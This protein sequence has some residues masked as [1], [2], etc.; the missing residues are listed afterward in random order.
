MNIIG[1][2]GVGPGTRAKTVGARESV[3]RHLKQRHDPITSFLDYAPE[4]GRIPINYFPLRGLGH[5][6]AAAMLVNGKLVAA[7][8]EERLNR[9]KHSISLDGENLLPRKS[10]D[11]CLE[12]AE[13]SWKD[14]DYICHYLDLSDTVMK[15]RLEILG[16]VLPAEVR[17][18]VLRANEVSF[19]TE[20]S[21]ESVFKQLQAL[22]GDA[23]QEHK[24]QCVPHHLSHAAASY[25]SSGFE[26]AGV[27][28]LDGYGEKDSAL[29]SIGN[30][31]RLE[32]IES[33][34]IPHSLGILYMVVTVFLGFKALNDEY[35]VMGLAPYGDPARYRNAFRDLI[36]VDDKGGYLTPLLTQPNLSEHLVGLFGPARKPEDPVSQREM[37]IAASLQERLEEVVL[38][39]LQRL[40]HEYGFDRLCLSGGVALNSVLNGK[41]AR[42]GL[43]KDIYVFPAAGDDGCAVGAAQ[44]FYH[45]VLGETGQCR[46]NSVYLGHGYGNTSIDAAL[47]KHRQEIVAE[48]S[49]DIARDVADLILD[50]QVVGWFQGQME[51]GPRAL[52]NRSIL[53]DARNPDMK[54]II[55]NKV[56]W[57]ESFRPFAPAVKHERV[58]E[59]FEMGSLN[60]SPF[61]LFVVKVSEQA[62]SQIPSTTHADGSA[63]VQTVK[64]DENARFWRLLDWLE[65]KSGIGVVLNTSF[66]V[67]GEPIVCAP[68]DA[69]RCFLKT[70]IDV[71]AI[72]DYIVRKRKED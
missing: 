16:S 32:A 41:V 51:F 37:D 55:N 58:A 33:I 29:F 47:A 36:L 14:V 40:K 72:G 10:L 4:E 71:L 15:R 8:A 18:S 60:E 66:N 7:V 5:D 38:A 9:R 57:R 11:Y 23:V 62:I 56:K 53:G 48:R 35:K 2:T 6:C 63:R 54:D 44:Y 3:L 46:V 43:F 52:G 13:K 12:V 21:R 22:T 25:Y 42:A 24:F 20:F 49:D 19:A 69:M 17:Q 50:Q 45:H 39:Y 31:Q 70:N 61:M 59:F 67:K 64:R 34:E 26:A 68:E 27:L 65:R 30:G 28:T 1:Y